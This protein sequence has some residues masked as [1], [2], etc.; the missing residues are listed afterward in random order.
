M[1]KSGQ[2]REWSF[3]SVELDRFTMY[4]GM[5]IEIVNES[6]K[7][8]VPLTLEMLRV[9]SCKQKQVYG[10]IENVSLKKWRSANLKFRSSEILERNR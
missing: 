7:L 10:S 8:M 5:N 4:T 9:S 2:N 6:V 1:V 3:N